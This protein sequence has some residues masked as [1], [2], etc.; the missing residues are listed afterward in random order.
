MKVYYRQRGKADTK[1]SDSYIKLNGNN[2][3]VNVD[4]VREIKLTKTKKILFGEDDGILFVGVVRRPNKGVNAWNPSHS[5]GSV[6]V[7]APKEVLEKFPKGKYTFS[8]HEEKNNITWY[9]LTKS[10]IVDYVRV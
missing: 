5:K 9:R 7:G 3:Y 1:K 2:I 8:H 10:M 6:S 4:A